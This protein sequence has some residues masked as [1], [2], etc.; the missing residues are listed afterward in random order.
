MPVSIGALESA[1]RRGLD[2]L[3]RMVEL[4]GGRRPEVRPHIGCSWCPVLER[5]DQG[6]A[7]VEA[8]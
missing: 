6:T 4:V 8:R 1:A 5:C 7:Y 2:A 3:A